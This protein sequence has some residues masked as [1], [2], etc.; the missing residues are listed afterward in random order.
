MINLIFV[1]SIFRDFVIKYRET[2]D[3]VVPSVE[4][5]FLPHEN[6]H[7]MCSA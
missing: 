6:L 4:V 5:G 2:S 1:F 7:N 3:N